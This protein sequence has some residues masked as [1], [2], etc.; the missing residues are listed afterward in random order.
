[1]FQDNFLAKIINLKKTN[2]PFAVATVIDIQG[3]ASARQGDKAIYDLNGKRVQGYVGG[4]CIENRVGKVVIDSIK[5]NSVRFLDV[6][7]DSDD[8]ELGIPCGGSMTLFIEPQMISPTILLRGIGRV[9]EV[10]LDFAKL[11]NFK[12]IIQTQKDEI[13]KFEKADKIILDPL[14]L[15]DIDEKID[16]FVLATHHRDDHK[17][18]LKAISSGI[19]YVAIIASQKKA[20]LIKNYLKKNNVSRVLMK[21]LFTPA[22][23]DINAKNAEEIALSIISQIVKI[24]NNKIKGK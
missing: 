23:I 13:N 21:N 9:V 22:G 14:D 6:N 19:K 16:Y 2:K 12:V 4:G 18:A 10:M 8:M 5:Y 1:M 11:L 3:S 24:E 17:Q 7:L 15:E 20:G